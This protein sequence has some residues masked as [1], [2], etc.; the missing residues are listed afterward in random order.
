MKTT[1]EKIIYLEQLLKKNGCPTSHITPYAIE[2]L[3]DC[4]KHNKCVTKVLL[5]TKN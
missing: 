5:T 2:I 3:S 1:T 4:K